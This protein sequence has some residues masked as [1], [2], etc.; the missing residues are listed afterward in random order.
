VK[1]RGIAFWRRIMSQL[2]DFLSLFDEQGCY[3]NR[4]GEIGVVFLTN[5]D[6]EYPGKFRFKGGI[7]SRPIH[8]SDRSENPPGT[9]SR[10]RPTLA[11]HSTSNHHGIQDRVQPLGSRGFDSFV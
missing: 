6:A 4:E 8:S 3:R 2:E 1:Q 9:S 5:S 7:W 10:R 11:L